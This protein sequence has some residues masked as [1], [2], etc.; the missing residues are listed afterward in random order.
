MGLMMAAF[1]YAAVDFTAACSSGQT[2]AYSIIDAGAKTCE[3]TKPETKPTGEVTIDATVVNP[4]DM[5][6][7]TV[8]GVG[9]KAFYEATGLTK[10]TFPTAATFTYIGHT[11]SLS[12]CLRDC[13]ELTG[14]LIIPDNVTEIG[15]AAFMGTNYSKLTIGTGVTEI[16][17][18]AFNDC[19]KLEHVEI[20]N[21]ITTVGQ[22]A[23]ANCSSLKYFAGGTGLTQLNYTAF[24]GCAN[25]DTLVL[26]TTTPPNVT[27]LFPAT[28]TTNAV[29]YV[30]STAVETYKAAQYFKDFSFIV[31]EG[32]PLTLYKVTFQNKIIND[33]CKVY[34]D[35][36]AV[37]YNQTAKFDASTPCHLQ[38]KPQRF[39]AVE[40]VKLN[41]VD[42]LSQF[43]DNEADVSFTEDA[44]LVVTWYQPVPAYDFAET[45]PSGQTLY[46]NIT[47]PVKHE[48]KVCNQ[49][50]LKGYT[51]N[52]DYGYIKR[53]DNGDWVQNTAI[54]PA[55]ALLIPA[56]ITHNNQTY[57]ITAIDTAA[58]IEC[59]G[60]TSVA[61]AEGLKTIDAA[62]FHDAGLSGTLIIP[63][64][65]ATVGEWAFRD[66]YITKADLGGTVDME[67]F[68]LL[69]NYQLKELVT[70]S[71]TKRILSYGCAA[72]YALNTIVIGENVE[73]V[74]S[75]AFYQNSGLKTVYCHA[76]TPPT[77]KLEPDATGA[78]TDWYNFSGAGSATLYVPKGTK[79][80]Y[81]AANCWKL[82]GT[83]EELPTTYTITTATT[84]ADMGGVIGGGIYA[85]NTD[86][87]LTAVPYEHYQFVKWS[88]EVTDNP[89]K[90]KVASDATYTAVFAPKPTAVGDYLTQVIDGVTWKYQVISTDPKEVKLVNSG[91]H[92]KTAS[93]DV[94]I[95]GTIKDYWGDTYQLTTI[96]GFT[97]YDN[98]TI[99]V[100]RFPEGVK[101]I[102][103]SALYYSN[104]EEWY[105]P[106][107]LVTLGNGNSAYVDKLK[108]IHFAGADNLENVAI[109]SSDLSKSAPIIANA[110]SDKPFIRDGV[111]VFFKGTAPA[112][113]DIPEGVKHIANRIFDAGSSYHGIKAIRLPASL[114]SIS[115]CAFYPMTS[116]SNFKT[117]YTR[118]IMPPKVNPS[119]TPF[120]NYETTVQVT[121]VVDCNANYEAYA[122]DDYWKKFHTKKQAT[123]YSYEV[124]YDETY[125]SATVVETTC[126]NAHFEATPKEYYEV[127]TWSTGETT[128]A[129]DVAL[130]QDTVVT[131]TFQLVRYTVRFLDYDGTE[132]Y[133]SMKVERGGNIGTI[134]TL[135]QN[136]KGY[137]AK[138]WTRSDE[139]AEQLGAITQDVDYTATYEI[140]KYTVT[141]L[142]YDDSEL[143]KQTLEYDAVITYNGAEPTRDADKQ[144]VYTFSGWDPAFES[145]VTKVTDSDMTFKAQY[146]TKLQKYTVTFLKAE[147]GEKIDEVIVSYGS[148]A[149]TVAPDVSSLTPS[150]KRFGGWSQDITNVQGN[151]TVWPIWKDKIYTVQF[152][153]PLDD[154]A[155][156]DEYENVPYGGKVAPPT[157]PVHEGY[158]F[159]GW[160]SDAYLNV[161]DDLVISAVYEKQTGLNNIEVE[162]TAT[163]FIH[164]GQLFIQ[165]DDE[166]FNA[167]GTRVK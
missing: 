154:N 144:Y 53:D 71:A 130:T 110:E 165:R 27:Y 41:G 21:T 96:A 73:F 42:I 79:A 19:E 97:F 137:T 113:L 77:V 129:I 80:A 36:N 4:N 65:C 92:Y 159:T 37:S 150:D 153:D 106:A 128:N 140:N 84:P 50:G 121:L 142:N 64:S 6:T 15:A 59:S 156:I 39:W 87:I 18:S 28:L 120:V 78:S 31:A 139:V 57:N 5:E 94:T 167:Q 24:N 62:A 43:V 112:M 135:P 72:S 16:P 44:T 35:G 70:T 9:V 138:Y 68:V 12:H 149:T 14:E 98:R 164:N 17:L 155:I 158:L 58:F 2:L 147:G 157:A 48:V 91:D 83:I 166:L 114:K 95:P 11:N 105:F 25:L 145:G 63:A 99:K 160:S 40:S 33:R 161:T 143:D 38:L 119:A 104:F 90:I 102:E 100:L 116:V 22:T 118:A 115:D 111:L 34:A 136:K 117:V 46:F 32:T 163:K 51:G 20:P 88:D 30:P 148:D 124:E 75:S 3:V 131:V 134:P 55:G 132:V 101:Y 45:V 107:S 141:F 52:S 66:C 86:T 146:S 85:E 10:V 127:A 76:A 125:G 54:R 122:A 8:I 29:L 49:S 7:Y 126:G 108:D 81:E 89:R 123:T 61:F 13:P 103:N 109:A 82:F 67:E 151:M 60:L 56:T 162:Q 47:D 93:G 69:G 74:S 23:F 1:S 152:I 133:P 26:K